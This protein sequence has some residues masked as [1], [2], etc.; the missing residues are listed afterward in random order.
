[1]EL[2]GVW[3]IKKMQNDSVAW[4]DLLKIRQLYLAGR[5]MVLED[6]KSTHFLHDV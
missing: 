6:A 5:T 3:R 1:M 4:K 2:L